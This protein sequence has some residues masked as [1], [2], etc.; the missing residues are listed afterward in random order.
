MEETQTPGDRGLVTREWLGTKILDAAQKKYHGKLCGLVLAGGTGAGKTT[1][2]R[3]LIED[4]PPGQ[5]SRKQ[6]LL[7]SKVI[8]SYIIPSRRL[9]PGT[10]IVQFLHS[11]YSQLCENNQCPGSSLRLTTAG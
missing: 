7:R 4:R 3:Q 2:C 6:S 5:M 8:A 1:F 10:N 9:S 11:V